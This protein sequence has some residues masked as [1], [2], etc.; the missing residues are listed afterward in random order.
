MYQFI[1][2]ECYL[3]DDANPNKNSFNFKFIDIYSDPKLL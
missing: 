1:E 3:Q 2:V